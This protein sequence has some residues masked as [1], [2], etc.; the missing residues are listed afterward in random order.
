MNSYYTLAI[1]YCTFCVRKHYFRPCFYVVQMHNTT[2]FSQ[3]CNLRNAHLYVFCQFNLVF[4]YGLWYNVSVQESSN[5]F[6]HFVTVWLTFSVIKID[7][8]PVMALLVCFIFLV[9]FRKIQIWSIA[10]GCVLYEYVSSNIMKGWT[11]L[12]YISVA[13]NFLG[14]EVH[15]KKNM[16][17]MNKNNRRK[18]K[19]DRQNGKW[20]SAHQMLTVLTNR[21]SGCT[22]VSHKNEDT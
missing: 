4:G 8:V 14:Q 10:L 11:Q 13:S 21:Q 12:F 5:F 15:T 2:S 16:E 6:V 20:D 22:V 9:L 7:T 3:I 18:T 19:S 17:K 1:S